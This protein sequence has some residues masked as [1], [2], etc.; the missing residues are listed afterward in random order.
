MSIASWRPNT[1]VSRRSGRRRCTRVRADTSKRT[2]PHP[3]AAMRATATRGVSARPATAKAPPARRPPT[4]MAGDRRCR[5]TSSRV[6][7]APTSPPTPS[8]ALSSP[9]PDSPIASRSSARSTS[10]MSTIPMRTYSAPT[11]RLSSRATGSR[12]TSRNRGA[13]AAV[14][15]RAG[16]CGT[17]SPATRTTAAQE[18]VPI[19]ISTPPA[20]SGTMSRPL[21]RGPARM[22]A[23][24]TDPEA[25]LP[26]VS[27]AV[28][29]ESS[30]SRA[31]CTGR[32][33]ATVTEATAASAATTANC[34]PA[35]SAAPQPMN[36]RACA[37]YPRARARPRARRSARRARPGARTAAGTSWTRATRL[38]ARTPP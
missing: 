36:A 15:W 12:T 3:L 17:P 29:S 9:G 30:G 24:S 22:A 37:A 11:S 28:V 6:T 1:A 34:A 18:S 10:R 14:P 5:P 19:V 20:P 27:S 2:F 33:I 21:S 25:A 7:A 32:V 38:A 26:A 31:L 35:A 23:D 13:G 4:T 16:A 8:I